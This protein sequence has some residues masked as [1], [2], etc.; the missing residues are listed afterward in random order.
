MGVDPELGLHQIKTSLSNICL[1]RESVYFAGN[2]RHD[3]AAHIPETSE[4]KKE[5]QMNHWQKKNGVN[6][7]KIS[8]HIILH[9]SLKRLFGCVVLMKAKWWGAASEAQM[10][11][12]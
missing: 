5:R 7:L 11:T 10:K 8:L 6:F 9:N 4:E 2:Y 3:I 1:Q 12:L